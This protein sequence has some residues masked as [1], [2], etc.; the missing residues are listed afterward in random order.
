MGAGRRSSTSSRGLGGLSESQL[1]E[2]FRVLPW[3]R[4]S[5]LESLVLYLLDVSGQWALGV[6]PGSATG[7]WVYRGTWDS[8]AAMQAELG[9]L[10]QQGHLPERLTVDE[11]NRAPLA[12][13]PMLDGVV[14]LPWLLANA[15]A[16]YAVWTDGQ[17]LAGAV[18][19][20]RDAEGTG[21]ADR[22]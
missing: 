21:G 17:D 2:H 20:C 22:P 13:A 11:G 10:R 16:W 4:A 1:R 3:D 5:P 7:R 14:W 6:L 12:L 8:L 19:A 9:R 18:F 15:V